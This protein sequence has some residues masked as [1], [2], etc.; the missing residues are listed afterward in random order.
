M[1]LETRIKDWFERLATLVKGK[2]AT[3]VSWTNIKT[4]N[5]QNLLWGWD[6]PISWSWIQIKEAT[7]SIPAKTNGRKT[8]NITDVT[9]VDTNKI[10]VQSTIA[11]E[12]NE[13]DEKEIQIVSAIAKNGSF[14]V[15]FETFGNV[16]W[17]FK[18]Y[19]VIS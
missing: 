19:Y 3:L 12:E 4:V 1:S 17:E 18:I 14:D 8:I 16:F 2:Q 10:F 13:E 11:G 9:L 6:I 5:G 7:L 15:T